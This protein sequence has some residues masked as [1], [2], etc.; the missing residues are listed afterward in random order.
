MLKGKLLDSVLI[1][2]FV[3]VS[4][5]SYHIIKCHYNFSFTSDKSE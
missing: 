2:N 4:I 1:I 5:N 3:A